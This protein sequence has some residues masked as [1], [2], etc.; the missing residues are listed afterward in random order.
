MK[1]KLLAL[2]LGAAVSFS[3]AAG[4]AIELPGGPIYFKFNGNEQIATGGLSTWTD[5]VDIAANPDHAGEINWGVFVMANMD[6]GKVNN[7]RVQITDTGDQFFINGV[8]NHGQVTGMFYGVEKGVVTPASG[9]FPASSGFMDLYWRDLDSMTKTK[10]SDTAPGVRTGYNTATGYTDGTFLARVIFDSGI[11]PTNPFNTISGDVDP[12]GAPGDF[13]G[14][15]NSFASIDVAAGGLWATKLDSNYFVS[16]FG[17]RDLRFKNSY[18]P[19][20]SWNGANG[21]LGAT[22]DDPGQ[23]FALPEPGALSLMGL[24]LVGMGAIRRRKQK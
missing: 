17:D 5:A 23:A 11:D 14:K 10:N 6:F 16:T 18:Q 1:S 24:A 19:L 15:A 21:I 20:V 12:A 7:P 9:A 13:D 2:A 22:L 3:A 4:P 8:T